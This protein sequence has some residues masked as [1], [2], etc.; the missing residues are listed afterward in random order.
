[1][2]VVYRKRQIMRDNAV[3]RMMLMAAA[4]ALLAG[5]A[6]A[7][8]GSKRHYDAQGRLTGTTER[9]SSGTRQHYDAQGRREGTT[10]CRG[11]T[12]RHYDARGRFTGRTDRR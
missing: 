5:P 11:T 10:E 7:Q 9:G 12:C 3:R 6:A 4:L 2:A 1:M 8:T